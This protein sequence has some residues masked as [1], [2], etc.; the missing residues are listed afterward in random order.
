MSELRPATANLPPENTEVLPFFFQ[1]ALSPPESA[2]P[3]RFPA[4][5]LLGLNH[6]SASCQHGGGEA[7]GEHPQTLTPGPIV[8]DL[9]PPVQNV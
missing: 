7:A 3:A 4:G 6:Q 5:Y 2:G 8:G 1:T 9:P